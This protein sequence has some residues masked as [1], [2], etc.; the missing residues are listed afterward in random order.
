[1]KPNPE[2][3]EFLAQPE[4]RIEPLKGVGRCLLNLKKRLSRASRS[5][6]A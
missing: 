5:G 6:S 1:M 2:V 3:A 4:L